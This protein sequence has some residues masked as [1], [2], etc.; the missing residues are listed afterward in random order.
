MTTTRYFLPAAGAGLLAVAASAALPKT[1]FYDKGMAPLWVPLLAAA[2]AITAALAS[3]RRVVLTCGWT[4]AV[5]FLWSAGGVVLD[6]FRAFYWAT[7]IP[8]GDFAQV[9]W[10]GALRRFVSL[11]AVA[12]IGAGT[13]RYQRTVEG[14]A[15]GGSWLGYVAFAVGFPYPML[16]L[17]WSLGG[18]IARPPIYAE[19]FPAMELVCLAAGAVLSLALV[20]SWGKRLPRGLVLVPAWFATGVLVSMAALMVFG[21]TS[22][23]LGITDGPVDFSDRQ[24]LIAVGTVYL[25]WLVFGLA[26]GGATLAYQRTTRRP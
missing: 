1:V 16:K 18:T 21:T 7:G 26:L 14:K 2:F 6:A 4:A 8:A 5:L 10:P 19:G 22:Q 11:V 24:S 17:Y 3:N 9:D 15:W 13:L 20:Q 23:L 25:S 12:V